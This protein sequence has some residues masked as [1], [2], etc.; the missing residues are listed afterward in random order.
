MDLALFPVHHA[1]AFRRATMTRDFRKVPLESIVREQFLARLNP[2][3]AEEEQA[4]ANPA[5]GKIGV[6]TV[7][8]ELGAAAAHRTIERPVFVQREEVR[9]FRLAAAQGLAAADALA[10]VLDYFTAGGNRLGG[11][12]APS[13]DGRGTQLQPKAGMLGV[14]PGWHYPKILSERHT[15]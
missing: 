12:D 15:R 9:Q 13:V 6:A 2:A 14:D 1:A 11:V 10:G 4:P 7:I 8:D 3:A 5:N